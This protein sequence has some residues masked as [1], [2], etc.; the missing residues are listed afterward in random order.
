MRSPGIALPSVGAATLTVTRV[1][2]QYG[3]RTFDLGNRRYLGGKSKLLE[4]IQ[5]QMENA[6][7]K[8]PNSVF[9]V[10]AG[11]GVVGYHFATQGVP[12]ISNDLLQHNYFAFQAFMGPQS[13]DLKQLAEKIVYLQNLSDEKN[14]FSEHFGGTFFS[15]LNAKKIGVIRDEIEIIAS[16]LREKAALV[17]SLIYAADRVANTVGHY[18]AFHRGQNIQTPIELKLPNILQIKSNANEAYCQDSITLAPQV[19]AEVAYLD[20]PYNSRQYSD[21]YHLLENLAA[22]EKPEVHGVAKKM[23]RSHLKS[24][25]CGK[26]APKTFAELISKLNAKL[27]MVSYNNTSESLN[28][29]SNAAIPDEEIINSLKSRGKVS[30]KEIA[31]NGFTTGKTKKREHSERLFICR[32]KE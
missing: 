14:Y 11:T 32:V 3:L 7:D 30:V 28:S 1:A 18:D 15:D 2:E 23:D 12:V 17:T 4:F 10:F 22:W 27:I 8:L 21:A 26:A 19:K 5:T 13:M 6:L 16:N 29:R 24:N 25:F 9:D 20:P 31:F